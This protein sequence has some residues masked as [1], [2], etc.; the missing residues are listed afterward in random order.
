MKAIEVR[1]HGGPE[2]LQTVTRQAPRFGPTEALVRQT[3]IGVNFVDLQHCLGTPYPMAVPFVPGIEAVGEVIAVG[4]SVRDDLLGRTVGYAGPMPGAYADLAAIEVAEL[5]EV[6][7]WLSAERAAAVFVQG[8]TATYLAHRA[9]AISP[10]MTV[11]VHAAGGGVGHFLV[12]WLTAK[13]ARVL[14]TTSNPRK[15]GDIEA[16]GADGVI[17]LTEPSQLPAQ[18]RAFGRCNVVYDSLGGP[19]VLPGLRCLASCGA[20]VGYGLAAGMPPPIGPAALAGHFGDGLSGSLRLSWVNMGDHL[21]TAEA[22]RQAAATLFE[23]LRQGILTE[24]PIR[25][26]A[27]EGAADAHRAFLAPGPSRKLILIPSHG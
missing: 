3:A 14:G 16:A 2:V 12:Q 17:V 20:Y 8:L 1:K 21:A 9:H 15:A 4:N 27:L 13:G 24:R 11:L 7:D 10:G 22:R 5:I 6:P 25:T 18:V 19:F 26:F 23:G